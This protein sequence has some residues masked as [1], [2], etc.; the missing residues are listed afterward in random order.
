MPKEI[1]RHCDCFPSFVYIGFVWIAWFY[2][3]WA[4]LGN[5]VRNNWLALKDPEVCGI[6]DPIGNPICDFVT[7]YFAL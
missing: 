7:K 2:M 5:V 1:K 3:N 6:L 4:E